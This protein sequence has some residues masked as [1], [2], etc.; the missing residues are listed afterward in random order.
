MRSIHKHAEPRALNQWK[1]DNR[2]SPQNL[3]Y[4][5]GGFPA[6]EIRQSLL[7]EQGHLCAYTM[8]RLKTARQCAAEG[9]STTAACHIEHLLP[10]SRQVPGEDIDYQNMV[11][12]FPPSQSSAACPYGAHKKADFDPTT[13]GFVSPLSNGAASHFAFG[14]DGAIRGVTP[15][16]EATIKILG[17]DHKILTHDRAAAIRGWLYPRGTTKKPVS[18]Q[19]AQRLIQ[20]LQTP[21]QEHC[22]QPFCEAAI[23]ALQKHALREEKRAARQRGQRNP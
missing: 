16:G 6:E 21:D 8:R 10:Q 11:A 2:D 23:Q 15:D 13:G 18:A 14:T 17:L 12:C 5:G 4:Q 7:T 22:L 19:Q 20:E 3:V 9:K 1:A